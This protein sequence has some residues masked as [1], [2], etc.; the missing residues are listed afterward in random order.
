MLMLEVISSIGI[1]E[2]LPL[3][4]GLKLDV[5]LDQR[6]RHPELKKGFH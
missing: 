1:E 2:R 6:D 4:Q 3:K 5:R